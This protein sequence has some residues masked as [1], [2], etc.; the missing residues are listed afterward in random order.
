MK[1]IKLYGELRKQFGKQYKFNVTTTSQALNAMCKMVKGFQDY[2]VKNSSPGFH[3]KVGREYIDQDELNNPSG[4][5]I[6]RISPY[7]VGSK[8]AFKAIIGIA[9]VVAAIAS[10]SW[11]LAGM[12]AL[13]SAALS[14]GMSLVLGGISELLFTPPKPQDAAAREQEARP[15]YSFDGPENTV[16]QGNPVPICYGE[17][18][19]G[20]QVI[21]AVTYAKDI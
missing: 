3:I 5:E 15:S 16:E 11:M 19:V 2:L 7:I 18:M 20:S 9:I 21:S 14:F 4:N 8:K 13:E 17:L 1:T 12:S 6:I 10:N